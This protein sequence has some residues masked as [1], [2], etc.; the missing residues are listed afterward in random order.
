[1]IQKP[2]FSL[3]L[4]AFVCAVPG[5]ALA[6]ADS[7]RQAVEQLFKLTHMEDRINEYCF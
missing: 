1:M 6:D 3:L 5:S 4:L 2:L 7:H